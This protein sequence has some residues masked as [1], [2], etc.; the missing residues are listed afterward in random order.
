MNNNLF[1]TIN[2]NQ[3]Q[4][5]SRVRVKYGEYGFRNPLGWAAGI[6]RLGKAVEG[7]FGLGFGFV[8]IGS[9]AN[10][11]NSAAL[12]QQ[13]RDLGADKYSKMLWDSKSLLYHSV[14]HSYGIGRVVNQILKRQKKIIDGKLTP[15][16]ENVIGINI[17]PSK[18]IFE[19][20]PYLIRSDYAETIDTAIELSDY[21]VINI[22]E[23]DKTKRKTMASVRSEKDL[24]KL[25]KRVNKSLALNLGKI[26][27]VEYA[28]VDPELDSKAGIVDIKYQ[29]YKMYV[30]NAMLAK[31]CVPLI[32]LKIDSYLTE[33]EYRT[34]AKVM[35]EQ[36]I[37]GAIIGSTIPIN[38]G[39]KDKSK[40]LLNDKPAMGGAGGDYTKHNSLKA[41][42]SMYEF[43]E[44]KKLL[45]S[46]GGIFSG[47]DMY[48]RMCNGA[49]LVQIY[50]A[51]SM[52]GPYVVQYMMDE[53][54]QILK[55]NNGMPFQR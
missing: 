15:D 46:S 41:L 10:E 22:T 23:F 4:N 14:Y 17:L 6:D 5:D 49:S 31:N 47:Q 24:T 32:M 50:S 16:P 28:K 18:S 13:H 33:K 44:G 8:E 27:A 21:L 52:R 25:W 3:D 53:F 48:N 40:R 51:L 36:H 20:I 34:I 55:Q 12:S 37:D 11:A 19:S 7:L 38:V 9:V 45:I 30:R 2:S 54:T 39:I 43:T 29:T 35:K 26:A 1:P 42:K